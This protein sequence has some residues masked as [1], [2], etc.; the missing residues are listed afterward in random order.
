MTDSNRGV[1]KT[2]FPNYGNNSDGT[3]TGPISGYE[4]TYNNGLTAFNSDGFTVG[5]KNEFN[6]N[7]ENFVSWNWKA[8]SNA[9]NSGG[10]I[11]TTV[12]ANQT[13]GFSIITYAGEGTPD[14][15]ANKTIGHGLSAA[16]TFVIIKKRSGG[17]GAT[18]G[19][20]KGGSWATTASAVVINLKKDWFV[21]GS[22]SD[23]VAY[24][25]HEV[26][27]F[28]KFGTYTGNGNADGPFIFTGFKPAWLLYKITSTTVAN[29][30]DWGIRDLKRDPANVS[31]TA[32]YANLVNAEGTTS[33]TFDILSNGFKARSTNSDSNQSGQTF[34]YMAF[35]EAP[36]KYANAR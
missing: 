12:S 20:A 9:S 32:L 18:A 36:F 13:A 6:T 34:L 31:N 4:A 21:N 29:G 15:T 22:S 11:T 24:A 2:L 25:W 8:G 17:S 5:S 1:Q 23:L 26:A 16:P 35:A 33:I 7:N 28:S 30:G 3:D 19:P 27:G 10:Q 14:S